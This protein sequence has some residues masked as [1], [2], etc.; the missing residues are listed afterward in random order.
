[1]SLTGSY[2]GVAI[3]APITFGYA[4]TSPH[5]V[6]WFI[7]STLREMLRAAGL[8]K[9]Q[10]DGLIVSSYRMAPDNAASLTEYLGISPRFIADLPYGGASGVMALRRAARA[11][12]CGDAD[13]IACIG[14]DVVP[15]P[16]ESG[17]NFST[18]ARDHVFPY[19]AGGANGVFSLITE[20]YA[21]AYG[22]TA[23][24][25]GQLCVAQRESAQSFP[26]ALLKGAMTMADY[27]NARRITDSLGLY[28]CVMRCCGADGFLVLSV[29]RA[30]AL[31]LP[32]ACIGGAVERH[33]AMPHEPVQISVGAAGDRDALYRQAGLEPAQ[34]DFVQA[35][36]DYPVIVMLQLES[37]GFCE[38]GTAAA[39]LRRHTLT[40]DGSF[41]LNTSGGMLSI[42]QAGAAGG[43]LGMTE[44]VRQLTGGALG[45]AVTNPRAGMVSCYGTV[46]YDRGLCWSAAILLRGA[47]A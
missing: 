2:E 24:D 33:N 13:I 46:N 22:S 20:G 1:M 11:V 43:Y 42:G 16:G 34:M 28:D 38:P 21:R 7:G 4:K 5:E 44:A 31:R 17:A 19:G 18:F 40:A 45:R 27:L 3:V 47:P 35:Y 39:F 26:P 37:L 10:V 29:D 9:T 41:P 36:D 15:P 6:P 32:Y 14:A 23:E 25:F 30:R 8:E 12:Q